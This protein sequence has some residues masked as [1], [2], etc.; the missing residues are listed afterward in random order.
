M[1][2]RYND[3]AIFSLRILKIYARLFLLLF[4]REKFQSP[5]CRTTTSRR[6]IRDA[7]Y[8]DLQRQR[9]AAGRQAS[10]F[11]QVLMTVSEVWRGTTVHPGSVVSGNFGN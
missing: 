8:R 1:E 9:L 2:E 5:F 10:V 3:T 4:A 6:D 11:P 7:E